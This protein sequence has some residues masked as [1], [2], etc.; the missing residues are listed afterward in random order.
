LVE[1]IPVS[2][3]KTRKI[4]KY[5]NSPETPLFHKGHVLYGLAQALPA[6]REKQQAL[7]TEGSP[8]SWRHWAQH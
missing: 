5:L 2:D 6:M 1:G 7:V 3:S 8:M 4:A